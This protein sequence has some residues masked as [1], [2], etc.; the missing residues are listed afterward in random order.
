MII[1][2]VVYNFRESS[3]QQVTVRGP[4]H[5]LPVTRNILGQIKPATD[6]VVQ[7]KEDIEV[8]GQKSTHS[9]HGTLVGVTVEVAVAISL[10]SFLVGA[11]STG[12]LWFI[13]S[14]AE[15]VKTVRFILTIFRLP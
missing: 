2:N 4:L 15:K 10:A 12:V 1:Q 8:D 5:I 11:S 13:H 6:H 14:K 7:D 9:P 3:I